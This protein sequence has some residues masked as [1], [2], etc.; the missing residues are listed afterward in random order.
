MSAEATQHAES[1]ATRCVWAPLD[2]DG[3]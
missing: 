3:A 1:V 2:S